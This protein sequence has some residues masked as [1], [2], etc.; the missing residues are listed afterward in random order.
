M[1]RQTSL[2]LL[3]VFAFES[4]HFC[5]LA[6][7]EACKIR[8]FEPAG[9][10]AVQID[11][12]WFDGANHTLHLAG[13]DGNHNMGELAKQKAT[14]RVV[15]I[16]QTGQFTNIV[17]RPPPAK[18]VE[19]EGFVRHT[20]GRDGKSL[21]AWDMLP[22]QTT[23]SLPQVQ[24]LAFGD[25][26]D[27]RL[28]AAK[29]APEVRDCSLRGLTALH[30]G[31]FALLCE[32]RIGKGQQF[33]F[34]VHTVGEAKSRNLKW[35][36]RPT[37]RGL[38]A[39]PNDDLLL[40]GVRWI[41]GQEGAWLVRSGWTDKPTFE[42]RLENPTWHQ[43]AVD[44]ATVMRNGDVVISG[45]AT[46]ASRIQNRG[47]FGWTLARLD[48]NGIV[49]WQLVYP[50]NLA[51]KP[52]QVTEKPDGSL[53]AFGADEILGDTRNIIV[54]FS[55]QGVIRTVH[56]LA[57]WTEIT[58]M[59]ISDNEIALVGK[60]GDGPKAKVRIVQTTLNCLAKLR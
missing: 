24:W 34:I 1:N 41:P 15:R 5:Q 52:R 9:L 51:G 7:A 10:S 43:R 58:A 40:F 30:A 37:V 4:V 39:Y 46:Q 27:S 36:S 50:V 8:D 59:A 11:A 17:P 38:A 3:A 35:P 48:P 60:V 22:T 31:G 14:L 57:D 32:H 53:I 29:T 13:V 55:S 12:A 54:E 19:V 20:Q 45:L 23:A 21:I 33:E 28:P 6:H 18:P 42:K 16:D 49:R 2:S 47:A 25:V 56:V 44:G 26:G